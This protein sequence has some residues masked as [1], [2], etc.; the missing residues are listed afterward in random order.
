MNNTASSKALGF[1]IFAVVTWMMSMP[2]AGWFVPAAYGTGTAHAVLVFG[3]IGLLIAAIAA[4]VRGDTWFAFFFMFWSAVA[5]GLSSHM[6]GPSVVPA[7]AGWLWL[8][9]GLVNLYLWIAAM[10]GGLGGA[11][12]LTVLLTALSIIATGIHGFVHTSILVRIDGYLGLAAAV[13]AFYVSATE[14]INSSAG[15]N[16]LPFGAGARS[17]GM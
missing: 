9:F 16:V 13:V 7:F 5:W 4:F 10:Q 2:D 15:R 6:G 3:M 17:G 1:G 8:A 11:I 14:I 12:S